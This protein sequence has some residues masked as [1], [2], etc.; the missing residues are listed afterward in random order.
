MSD[1]GLCAKDKTM[2]KEDM[3]LASQ[4]SYS[5][6]RKANKDYSGDT[7]ETKSTW[8]LCKYTARSP[9]QSTTVTE[10]FVG[11]VTLLSSDLK[12]TW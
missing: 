7:L 2:S 1:P 12:D 9:T 5:L 6:L 3:I 10:G 8:R 11:N 4:E